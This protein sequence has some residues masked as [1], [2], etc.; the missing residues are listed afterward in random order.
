MATVTK[1][2]HQA[3]EE[4]DSTLLPIRVETMPELV[5]HSLDTDRFIARLSGAFGLLAMLLAAIGLYGLMAY[6]VARR[7]RDI[8]IRMALGAE[9]GNVL[10][11]VLRE[12]LLLVL[13]G[14]GAGL[15]AALGGTRLVRSMLFGLG[16]TDVAT[17]ASATLLLSVVAVLAG[18]LPARRATKVD[19]LVALRYE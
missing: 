1:A 14:I 5:G 17:I 6:N 12:T 18:F 13:L 4:T 11:L 9:P 16:A 8:G 10:W 3:V 15:P 19:P 2:I 7:T